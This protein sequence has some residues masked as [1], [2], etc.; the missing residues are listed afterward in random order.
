MAEI[1]PT[2]SWSLTERLIYVKQQ[3]RLVVD[4]DQAIDLGEDTIHRIALTGA[5]GVPRARSISRTLAERVAMTANYVHDQ[6][7]QR[8]V[9]MLRVETDPQRR[10]LIERLLAEERAN[11]PG[12]DVTAS[13]KKPK[14]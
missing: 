2:V 6:N 7:I 5:A 12:A 8:F 4:V 9:Q 13:P 10:L 1:R 11:T 14:A 3:A